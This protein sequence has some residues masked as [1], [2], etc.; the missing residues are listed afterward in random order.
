MQVTPGDH[1]VTV[2]CGRRC[3]DFTQKVTVPTAGGQIFLVAKPR[4]SQLTFNYD[5][6]GA[7]VKVT[8]PDD[9]EFDG[10]PPGTRSVTK[11][12]SESVTHPFVI[13]A[14][15]GVTGVHAQYEITSPGMRPENGPLD[16]AAGEPKAM[17]GNLEQ[18]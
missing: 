6:P 4:P 16:I 1:Q 3:E 13:R 8:L 18:R 9:A 10:A 17:S 14:T 7:T 15:P 12:A 2:G 5:P 11:T